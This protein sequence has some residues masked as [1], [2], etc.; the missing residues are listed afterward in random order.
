M[1]Q[2][3]CVSPDLCV[4]P[5]FIGLRSN[6]SFSVQIPPHTHT[7]TSPKKLLFAKLDIFITYS[8]Q[9]MWP[10]CATVLH[11]I[12]FHWPCSRESVSFPS[13]FR[14]AASLLLLLPS[15][16][17]VVEQKAAATSACVS[18]LAETLL[19]EAAA[20]IGLFFRKMKQ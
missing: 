12:A 8:L 15:L 11:P 13:A 16:E 4:A 9:K 1:P 2:P 10:W 17:T 20:L 14:A 5:L 6:G 7:H 19:N 18:I 3:L